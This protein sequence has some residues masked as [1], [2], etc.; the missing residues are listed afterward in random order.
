MRASEFYLLRAEGALRGYSNMGVTPKELYEE[1]IRKSIEEWGV[2][3]G[4]EIESYITSTNTPAPYETSF[5]ASW[6]LPPLSDIPVAWDE[7]GDFERNL[8][9]SITQKWI[10]LYPEG[11]EA[12]A[13][14]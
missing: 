8:E 4:A 7:G 10:A 14:D 6:N 5:D 1:G 12:Y 9:Q 2:A 3:S 13:E 11:M